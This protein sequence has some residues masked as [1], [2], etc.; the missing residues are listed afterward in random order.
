M[1]TPKSPRTTRI[2]E[3]REM[4]KKKKQMNL[5]L[6]GTAAILIV[7]A[8][9]AAI[10]F[11]TYTSRY[12]AFSPEKMA[13]AYVDTIA[14]T[15]DGYN[16]YKNTLLSKDM[17]FGDYI[18]ENYINPVVY[19]N[20][21]P[22]DSTK[23]LKGLNDEAL[24][25]EKTLNDDGTLKGKM[26]D[27]M[28]PFFEELITANSGFDNCDL[29]FTSYIE[30][31]VEVRQEIF[32]DKYFDDEA[33]FTAFEA[34]VLTYGESLTGTE[35][36]YDS[37]TGVQTKFASTGA[38]QEKFGDDYKIEVVSNG[39]KEGSADADKAVVNINVLVNGKVEIENLPVTLVKIGRSWYVDSTACDT[40]ELYGFYK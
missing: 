30:K 38:Y 29:I 12:T 9:L 19:E 11:F 13:V 10:T 5:K 23:G 7:A 39:F 27:E 15:G 34:N 26:I 25:G 4:A 28:Y 3:V 36:E 21:K 6:Y 14:Q 18:R 2:E 37:N 31:L 40:S 1:L 35:D 16:A 33:F 22:G 20:Y 17:K 24:K 8:V 32:G